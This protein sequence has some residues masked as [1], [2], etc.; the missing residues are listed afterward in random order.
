MTPITTK[1]RISLPHLDTLPNR[2]TTPHTK[3][4]RPLHR[5][6]QALR[7]HRALPT[8][9]H[10]RDIVVPML[11][12]EQLRINLTAE[13]VLHEPHL[14]FHKHL[15]MRVAAALTRIALVH[16]TTRYARFRLVNNA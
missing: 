7:L 5:V 11:R 16:V 2:R 12:E 1:K 4:F 3:K 14:S 9:R 8:N 15:N 13:S 6:T 10:R